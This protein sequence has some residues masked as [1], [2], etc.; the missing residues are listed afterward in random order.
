MSKKSN[1]HAN[2]G[3]VIGILGFIASIG[4]LFTESWLIGIFGSIASAGLAY[5]GY[6]DSKIE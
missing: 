3:L 4:L 1:T 5:K 6:Y 2:F